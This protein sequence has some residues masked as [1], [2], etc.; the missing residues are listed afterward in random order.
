MSATP[1]HLDAENVDKF[2]F[3]QIG[4]DFTKWN[5]TIMDI[6]MPQTNVGLNLLNNFESRD[7]RTESGT[8]PD[9]C[10]VVTGHF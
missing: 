2:M 3:L 10:N 5:F 9:G 7:S 4:F 8:S 1:S 6:S